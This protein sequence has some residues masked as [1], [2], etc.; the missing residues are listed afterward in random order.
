MPKR[1]DQHMSDRRQEILD[2]AQ[3]EFQKKG[4]HQTSITDI[5][6]A[7]RISVG[8]L[9]THFE[10]KRAI[11]L[12]LTE[13][14]NAAYLPGQFDSLEAFRAAFNLKLVEAR[15][16]LGAVEMDFQLFAEAVSDPE[17]HA[18]V[19]SSFEQR[20]AFLQ[21]ILSSLQKKGKIAKTYDPRHG[22]SRL[23]V[24]LLGAITRNYFLTA[25]K[26]FSLTDSIEAEFALMKKPG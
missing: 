19:R 9:Y 8:A 16:A 24:L 18:S 25:D 5:C 10:N 14:L 4:F 3:Q 12:A 7:A 21:D 23:N 1:S 2:A 26:Y 22:A 11:I 20:E 17:V 13:Q 6:R 15:N